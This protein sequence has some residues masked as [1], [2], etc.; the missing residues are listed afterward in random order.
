MN[1]RKEA[2][3]RECQIR[4]PGTC[5]GNNETVV[6]C[7]LNNKRLFGVGTGQKVPDI[8]GAW[9]CS[10]CHDAVDGRTDVLVCDH[11]VVTREYFYEGVFRTQNILLSE[12]KLGETK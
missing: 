7:H 11:E 10:S 5:N 1:L 12:G 3:G 6:L 9:G 8:F 4:I 2:R